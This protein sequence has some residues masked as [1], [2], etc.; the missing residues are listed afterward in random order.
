MFSQSE[1]PSTESTS[2]TEL[3][4]ALNEHRPFTQ[5]HYALKQLILVTTLLPGVVCD[6]Y[7]LYCMNA[8]VRPCG[9]KKVE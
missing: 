6:S 2:C 3:L 8:F 1:T 5:K 9:M 4:Q 7:C